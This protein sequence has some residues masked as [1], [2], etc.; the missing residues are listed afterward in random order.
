[1]SETISESQSKGSFSS[2]PGA[3]TGHR[4]LDVFIGTWNTE[5]RQLPGPVGPA[6]KVSAVETYEW[7]TGG[8][9]LVHRFEGDVGGAEAACIEIIGRETADGTYPVH[10]YYNN[11]VANEWLLQKGDGAWTLTGVWELAGMSMNVRCTIVFS[12]DGNTRTGKWEHSGDGAPWQ[13][14]WEVKSTKAGH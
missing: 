11:G 1:M 4:S 5:G 7:L 2:R 14:F 6:A 12:A 8:S 3:R 13:T 9:F 10:T